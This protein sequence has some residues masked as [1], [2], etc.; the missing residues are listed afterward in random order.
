MLNSRFSR[1][2]TW[3]AAHPKGVLFA[4]L[5]VIA[6]GAWGA[7]ELPD[8]AVGG[9]GDIEGSP[10]KAVSE[11]L[12]SEFTNPFLDPLVVAVSAPA[13]DIDKEPYRAWVRQ[14]AGAVGALPDVRK[15]SSYADAPDARMRSVDGH[16]TMILVGL[17]ATDIEG[18]QRAVAV[19]RSA[20]APLRGA[21]MAQDPAAQVA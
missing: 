7:H 2:G 12:R 5:I 1:L 8:A 10:S 20:M 16:V 18:Q 4:W 19:V 3:V 21:L 15:V 9:T 11:A 17:A 14:A 13:L 6:F